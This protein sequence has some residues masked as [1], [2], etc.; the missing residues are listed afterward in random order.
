MTGLDPTISLK[1]GT[2]TPLDP[3]GS[4]QKA[5]GILTGAQQLQNLRAQEEATRAGTRVT[6]V[7]AQTAEREL[8]A[9]R[10]LEQ[11]SRR[12]MRMSSKTG[13]RELDYSAL[14]AAMA[15]QGFSDLAPAIQAQYA[16]NTAQAISND[17][18]EQT[19]AQTAVRFG[20]EMATMDASILRSLTPQQ[21]LV[22]VRRNLDGLKNVAPEA[23]AAYEMLLGQNEIGAQV[24]ALYNAPRTSQQL[25]DEELTRIQLGQSAESIAQAGFANQAGPQFRD[26]NSPISR[27]TAARVGQAGVAVPAGIPAGAIVRTPG[28]QEQVASTIPS[29]QTRTDLTVQAGDIAA[30]ATAVR[31]AANLAGQ[32][33]NQYGRPGSIARRDWNTL[34]NQNPQYAEIQSQIEAY[35]AANPGSKLDVLDGFDAIQ[36]R[37]N[38]FATEQEKRATVRADAAQVN[39]GTPL[40]QPS[41]IP[42]AAPQSQQI[43]V[44]AI[45]SIGGRPHVFT[46][47]NPR[48]RKNWRP[49]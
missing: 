37:L 22:Q 26:P 25:T 28:V 30:A 29:A 44:G 34:V 19:R 40:P 18:N 16:Q 5:Q 33:K 6:N 46:G 10:W 47:G 3:I 11:N 17:T 48:D 31:N 20:R 32:L 13:A 12:F 9:K 23:A 45:R 35:N 41:Q 36:R 2:Q 14:T 27:F 7:Q 15:E 4:I 39:P 49:Q 42:T 1:A 21:A 24:M 43:S 38:I 8:Q